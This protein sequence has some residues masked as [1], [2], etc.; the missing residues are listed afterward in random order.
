MA[1]KTLATG[2]VPAWR[3]TI[4]IPQ[5]LFL[6]VMA[7]AGTSLGPLVLAACCWSWSEDPP[8]TLLRDVEAVRVRL[9]LTARQM[10]DVWPLLTSVFAADVPQHPDRMGCARLMAQGLQRQRRSTTNQALGARGG[11]ARQLALL[12]DALGD[13]TGEANREANATP[14][15]KPMG[16][17]SLPHG[18]SQWGSERH[19]DGEAIGSPNAS[20][21]GKPTVPQSLPRPRGTTA[22]L[23]ARVDAP[24]AEGPPGGLPPL[25]RGEAPPGPPDAGAIAA[26][27]AAPVVDGHPK[28]APHRAARLFD[29]V[30]VGAVV[31]TLA[32]PRTPR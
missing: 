25:N 26:R 22:P 31:A 30:P 1:R 9:G 8:G 6:D 16:K 10:H 32:A 23:S 3:H 7:R 11:R 5:P 27:L 29:A 15:G 2:G 19:P 28:H 24:E 17:P 21:P 13:A 20:P 14:T 18:G 4:E 12:P